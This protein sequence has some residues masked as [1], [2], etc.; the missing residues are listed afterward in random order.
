MA[1]ISAKKISANFIGKMK[2][3]GSCATGETKYS[4]DIGLTK[5]VMSG[6]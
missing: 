1:L 3:D 5:T 4:A 2:V 6:L